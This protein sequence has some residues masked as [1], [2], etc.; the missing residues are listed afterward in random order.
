MKSHAWQNHPEHSG[1]KGPP[2]IEEGADDLG[3][4]VKGAGVEGAGVLG[5]V[6]GALACPPHSGEENNVPPSLN[7]GLFL[8]PLAKL[9][10][11]SSESHLPLP[12]LSYV[13]TGSLLMMAART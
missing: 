12:F 10:F 7:A 3:A 5:V 9:A 4:G 1:T 2:R 13:P 8:A 11:T 6:G